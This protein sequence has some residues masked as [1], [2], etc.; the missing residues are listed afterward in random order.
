M[1][2]AQPHPVPRSGTAGIY[3]QQRSEMVLGH[4]SQVQPLRH[5]KAVPGSL[6]G[7]SWLPEGQTEGADPRIFRLPGLTERKR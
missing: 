5:G 2:G 1:W 3:T 6:S 7:G 4:S